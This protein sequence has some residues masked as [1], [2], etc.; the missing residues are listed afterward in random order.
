MSSKT[1]CDIC[2]QQ[3]TGVNCI[4]IE[5]REPSTYIYKDFHID[6]FNYHFSCDIRKIKELK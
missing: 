3:I 1:Y 2:G 5:Y 6:C 4:R